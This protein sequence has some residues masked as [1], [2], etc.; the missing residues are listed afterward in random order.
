MFCNMNYRFLY[1]NVD[2]AL[3]RAHA[4]LVPKVDHITQSKFTAV[5]RN[6]AQTDP[7]FSTTKSSFMSSISK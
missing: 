3:E 7:F 6:T 4:E 1:V 2:E 5:V